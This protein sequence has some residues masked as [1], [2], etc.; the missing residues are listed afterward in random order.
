MCEYFGL[1]QNVPWSYHPV[2]KS[3][4]EQEGRRE[5]ERKHLHS[6]RT[7]TALCHQHILRHKIAREKHLGVTLFESVCVR[8]SV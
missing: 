5:I 2:R 3:E 1:K 8:E 6:I 4:R 7:Y